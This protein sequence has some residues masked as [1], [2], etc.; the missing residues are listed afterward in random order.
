MTKKTRLFQLAYYVLVLLL[1]AVFFYGTFKLFSLSGAADNLGAVILFVCGI[2]YV[3]TPALVAVM[4]RFSL[5]KWYV[6]PFAASEI[7]LFFYC[8]MVLKQVKTSGNLFAAFQSVHADL[9]DSKAALFLLCLF[10]IGLLASF[11]PARKRGESLSYRLLSKIA[12][13]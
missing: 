11:S 3:A 6:D 1:Y 7:P 4:M 2:L 10:L 5:L 9:A 13:K 12:K 8:I